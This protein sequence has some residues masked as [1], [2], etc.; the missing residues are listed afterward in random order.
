MCGVV[1]MCVCVCVLTASCAANASAA[2]CRSRAQT[3]FRV[4]DTRGFAMSGAQSSIEWQREFE[5]EFA[6]LLTG[7]VRSTERMRRMSDGKCESDTDAAAAAAAGAAAEPPR[8]LPPTGVHAA[9]STRLPHVLVWVVSALDL[10]ADS[11]ADGSGESVMRTAVWRAV[12]YARATLGLTIVTVITCV[13]AAERTHQDAERRARER[14]AML[15]SDA[16][17]CVFVVRNYCDSRS[18][19]DVDTDL[20]ALRVLACALRHAERVMSERVARVA[21]HLPRQASGRAAHGSAANDDA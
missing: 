2:R 14:A 3:C 4:Q 21:A 11:D 12:H 20:A 17:E 1:C 13:D 5:Q 7:C 9:A 15:N 10:L 6:A 19:P 16:A 8:A 18:E